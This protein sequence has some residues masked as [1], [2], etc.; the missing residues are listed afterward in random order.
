MPM[1]T[2]PSDLE[3]VSDVDFNEERPDSFSTGLGGFDELLGGGLAPGTVAVVEY[4][5]E[6]SGDQLGYSFLRES[7]HKTLYMSSFRPVEL[8]Q[9][10]VTETDAR[11]GETDVQGTIVE[12]DELKEATEGNILKGLEQIAPGFQGA[13]VVVDV[14]SDL[15]PNDPS[16]EESLL[17]FAQFIK[18]RGGCAYLMVHPTQAGP[19]K[20]IVERAKYVSD[21]VIAYDTAASAQGNDR[22]EVSKARNLLSGGD[23]L[24]IS[25]ELEITQGLSVS[26]DQ[27]FS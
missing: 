6:S 3:S 4:P 18:D 7:G 17:A 16:W 19:K 10:S 27:T 25:I 13:T 23:E 8:V 9:E 12:I 2:E 21:I 11:M 22:L 15:A 24:P 26:R 14:Y 20:Q 5:P 1:N